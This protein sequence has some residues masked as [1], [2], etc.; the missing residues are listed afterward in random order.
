M[1]LHGAEAK[2]TPN[3]DSAPAP[4]PRGARGQVDWEATLYSPSPGA[5]VQG[6]WGGCSPV[7]SCGTTWLARVTTGAPGLGSECGLRHGQMTPSWET[8][9]KAVWLE[10]APCSGTCHKMS[11]LLPRR[12]VRV[13]WRDPSHGALGLWSPGASQGAEGKPCAR[14]QKK[15]QPAGRGQWGQMPALPAPGP[16]GQGP[17]GGGGAGPR[18]WTDLAE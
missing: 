3:A 10:P 12:V 7:T 2:L 1:T 5:A 17:A 13:N 9:H 11:R 16:T 8:A 14:T 15:T 6:L 4:G 18:T